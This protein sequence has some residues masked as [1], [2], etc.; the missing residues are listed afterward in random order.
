MAKRYGRAYTS[1][2][3]NTSSNA[4]DYDTGIFEDDIERMRREAQKKEE[5]EN[6]I[7]KRKG[8]IHRIK[9]TAAIF[10]FR[11]IP[12]SFLKFLQAALLQWLQMQRLTGREWKT[13][14]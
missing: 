12:I 7:I 2:R 14:S 13:T 4:Y 11:H 9:F 6:E 8:F 10:L 5:R 1:S 3:Y